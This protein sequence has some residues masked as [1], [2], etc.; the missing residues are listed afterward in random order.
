MNPWFVL[1]DIVRA[2]LFSVAHVAGGSFGAAIIVVSMIARITLL[3]L[4]LR[5]ARNAR[6]HQD[7]LRQMEP[8]LASIRARHA[9]DFA[10]QAEATQALRRKHG[11][12]MMP[13]GTLSAM[14]VQSPIYALLYRAISTS[15]K[16][17]G[18]FL[19]IGDLAKPDIIVAGI[20][21]LLAAASARTDAAS[22]ASSNAPALV[23]GVITLWIAWRLTS[24]VGLYWVTSSAVGLGQ[25]LLLRAERTNART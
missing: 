19:W 4:T 13:R 18:G 23:S 14:L 1:V 3:P 5:M 8:E 25:S 21:A 2:L 22:N 12:G 10:R 24:G 20:A 17:I 6:A 9:N 15:A 11:V 7:A 16:A